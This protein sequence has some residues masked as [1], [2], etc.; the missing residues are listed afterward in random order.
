MTMP[1]VDV[2]TVKPEATGQEFGEFPLCSGAIKTGL[3]H[4]WAIR[5]APDCPQSELGTVA[6]DLGY[7]CKSQL[8]TPVPRYYGLR[9]HPFNS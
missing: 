3:G 4:R 2:T 9:V 5:T 1:D 7:E 8:L 6:I